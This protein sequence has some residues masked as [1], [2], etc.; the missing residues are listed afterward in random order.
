LQWLELAF[1]CIN[2][3]VYQE[4][5]CE[6]YLTGLKREELVKLALCAAATRKRVKPPAKARL[7]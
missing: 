6:L 1:P 5:F 3:P 4:L 2:D 7:A